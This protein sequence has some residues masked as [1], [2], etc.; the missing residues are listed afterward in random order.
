MLLMVLTLCESYDFIRLLLFDS[1]EQ[2]LSDTYLTCIISNFE[3]ICFQIAEITRR[4]N[5]TPPN[6]LLLVLVNVLLVQNSC[7][8]C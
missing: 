1:F 5:L 4:W 7:P 6:A 2:T 3:T 8:A